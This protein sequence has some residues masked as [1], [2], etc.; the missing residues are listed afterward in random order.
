VNS[1]AVVVAHHHRVGELA[2]QRLDLDAI[3][4]GLKAWTY[5]SAC[6]KGATISRDSAG[7]HV[8]ALMP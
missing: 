1:D 5:S 2:A 8:R 4:D 3:G 7:D 6:R